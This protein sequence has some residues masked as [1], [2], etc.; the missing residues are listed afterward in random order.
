MVEGD[1]R[2]DACVSCDEA[3]VAGFGVGEGESDFDGFFVEDPVFLEV[4]DVVP[5]EVVG[6]LE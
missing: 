1:S 5:L 6:F 2:E 3:L 4:L